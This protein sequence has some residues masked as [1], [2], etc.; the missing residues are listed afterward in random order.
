MR[1]VAL[2]DIRGA[3]TAIRPVGCAARDRTTERLPRWSD[4]ADQG[5]T[6]FRLTDG[7]HPR[8]RRSRIR[9]VATTAGTLRLGFQLPPLIRTPIR[10]SRK[11]GR[12]D[13][14]TGYRRTLVGLVQAG[15]EVAH[16]GA[17]RRMKYCRPLIPRCHAAEMSEPSLAVDVV[18]SGAS[19]R[20]GFVKIPCR[21]W[22]VTLPCNQTM[23]KGTA[24]HHRWRSRVAVVMAVA[25]EPIRTTTR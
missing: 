11:L 6:S 3:D 9:C 16:S 4:L 14:R 8:S 23:S 13:T 17:S 19:R 1:K 5:N 7:P 10:A 25:P 22:T 20:F 12:I 18:I 21:K 2:P 15:R 24:G